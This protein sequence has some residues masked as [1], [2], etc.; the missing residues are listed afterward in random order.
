MSVLLAD[1]AYELLNAVALLWIVLGFFL[2]SANVLIGPGIPRGGERSG[3]DDLELTLRD[4]EVFITQQVKSIPMLLQ[5]GDMIRD[6][7]VVIS[8]VAPD[9]SHYRQSSL[10]ALGLVY[11]LKVSPH[12][13]RSFTL[14]DMDVLSGGDVCHD[15]HLGEVVVVLPVPRIDKIVGARECTVCVA[16]QLIVTHSALHLIAPAAPVSLIKL[17]ELHGCWAVMCGDFIDVIAY[18]FP[19][20]GIGDK[21]YHACVRHDDRGRFVLLNK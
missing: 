15:E 11:S 21:G 18:A 12:S 14:A 2:S 9:V 13:S 6:I 19:C 16:A 7:G 10:V 20:G 1:K 17:G 4:G 5:S 3:Y 8:R